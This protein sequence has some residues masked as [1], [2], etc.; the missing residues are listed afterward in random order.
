MGQQEPLWRPS[1]E[2]AA[3]SA[4]AAFMASAGESR[5]APFADYEELWRW[6]VDQLEDFWA[7]LWRS[8][9]VIASEPYTRVLASREMPGARWFA[10]AKLNYAELSLIHI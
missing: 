9:R 4:M 2:R 6:S 5:G 8:S 10:D 1:S 3:A 7:E